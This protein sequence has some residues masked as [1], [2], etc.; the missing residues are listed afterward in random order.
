MLSHAWIESIQ[1]TLQHR[2]RVQE[3]VYTVPRLQ[4]LPLVLPQ[5]SAVAAI[6]GRPPYW[7]PSLQPSWDAR[8]YQLPDDVPSLVEAVPHEPPLAY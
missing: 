7:G 8:P 6:A 3:A 2:S 1:A 4:P 5:P